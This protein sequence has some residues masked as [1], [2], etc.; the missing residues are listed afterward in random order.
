MSIPEPPFSDPQPPVL[1]AVPSSVGKITLTLPEALQRAAAAYSRRDWVEAE[2]LCRLVLNARTDNFDALTLL[3]I[4]AAQTQR[5]QEAVEL[6]GR[7]VSANPNNAIA[8]SNHGNALRELKRLDEALTRYE[9]AVKLAPDFADAYNNRGTALQEL[10][11]LDEALAS[12]EQAI[13]LR[14]DYAEAY[15]NRGHALQE[16]KRLDEALASF[17]EVIKRKPDS[18]EAYN[19]RGTALGEL[20]RL[21][22]ALASYDAAIKRKP[23]Y[24][25]AYYNRGRALQELKRLD[26]ALESYAQAIKLR[27]DY[28]E[29][30]NNS[31]NALQE[32][33]RLE[34]A[35]AS[36]ELAITLEPGFAEAYCNRGLALQELKRLDEALD[37]CEQ[38]IKLR[39]DF[40]E[41]YR[42]RGN[43]LQE[44]KRLDEALDSY[45]K[46]LSIEP[47]FEFLFGSRLHLK[48]RMCDWSDAE[49]Q[50]TEL[51]QKVQLNEK[52][53]SP[54]PVLAITDSSALQRKAAEI[55]VNDKYPAS[56]ALPKFPRRQKTGKIRIGYFSADF[57]NHPVAFQT[58]G[59][60]ETHDRSRFE[61][62]GFSFGPN[63]QDEMTQRMEA[64]FGRF[65]DVRAHSDK[66]V[67]LLSRNLEIDIAVDLGGFTQD[68]RTKIFALRAAPLQVSYLGYPATMG[69]EYIDYIIADGVLI[70]NA[71]R[72]YYAEKVAYL[73]NSYFV[74]DRARAVAE[75]TFSREELGLPATGFVFCCFNNSYK[76][77]PDTFDGW[78]R[79]LGQVEGSVL[80]LSEANPTAVLNLRKEA[81]ARGIRA[82]RLIFAKRMLLMEEHLARLR[83][84]DMFIDTFPYNAHATGSD[85]LWAGLPVL[86]R[87]GHTF[88][89]RVAASL[90]NAIGL[91]EL[92]T[93][94]QSEYEALAIE[95]ATNPDRLIQIRKKLEANR[96]AAPLFDTELF[97][98]HMENAYV[99]MYERYHADLPPDH[100][101]VKGL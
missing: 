46:A 66:E 77:N 7:A 30:H 15:S 9:Q 10:K 67:A 73:P 79:I 98:R 18:A 80:W 44:L 1:P 86:T 100:I 53:T 74:N 3:G 35:L 14:P 8:H 58:A 88:A 34:E 48:M 63:M 22:E 6:F 25:E 19:N 101:Y 55:W 57:R 64:A 42:N 43:A 29:A 93:K 12:Y 28:L 45:D 78:M 38:A 23:D 20:K 40:A 33:K 51:F 60:F 26:E 91:P 92:I 70:P 17:D 11:R 61:L 71:S 39:P 56:L 97:T 59:L 5:T 13:K 82:A 36:Y 21:D 75:K 96:L 72:Q 87:V 81:E 16:L 37:S 24:A 69:A 32:L 99:Q 95:L 54:F 85:A 76:I 27:P 65:V 50:I 47:G 52:V 68:S 89:G 49:S 2:R 62:T 41:A 90:L 83:A 4:I 84:A 31:G 94:T